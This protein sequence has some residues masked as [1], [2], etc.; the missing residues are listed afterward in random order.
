M[1]ICV[2]DNGEECDALREKKCPGCSF[3][4]SPEEFKEGREKAT[5]R[6]EKLPMPT[7]IHIHRKYYNT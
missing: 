4:K 3:R 7:R 1:K 5:D 6:L 2:F